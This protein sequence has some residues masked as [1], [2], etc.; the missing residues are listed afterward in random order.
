MGNIHFSEYKIIQKHCC[1]ANDIFFIII[2]RTMFSYES[3]QYLRRA[4]T[5][6]FEKT[7][8]GGIDFVVRGIFVC[9]LLVI[10]L[11]FPIII[12]QSRISFQYLLHKLWIYTSSANGFSIYPYP[13]AT[14]NKQRSFYVKHDQIPCKKALTG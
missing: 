6:G 2:I 12:I 1:L 3:S 8:S 14:I 10:H 11:R 5:G 9:A 7:E 4:E 13:N